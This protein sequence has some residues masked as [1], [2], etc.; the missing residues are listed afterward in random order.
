MRRLYLT[1]LIP[2]I[3][4]KLILLEWR[5]ASRNEHQINRALFGAS[6]EPVKNNSACAT[7]A[8]EALT[9]FNDA[10]SIDLLLASA[11][12]RSTFKNDLIVDAEAFMRRYTRLISAQTVA[13]DDFDVKIRVLAIS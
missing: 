9:I 8:P 13:I 6:C 4:A 3:S 2:K 12:T 7:L 11:K 1:E 10:Y 5:C